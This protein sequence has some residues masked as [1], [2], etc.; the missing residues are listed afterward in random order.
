MAMKRS[1]FN[2]IVLVIPLLG[3]FLGALLTPH[4]V[5]ADIKSCDDLAALEADPLAQSAPVD[6]NDIQANAVITACIAALNDPLLG[7]KMKQDETLKARL[8]LQLGRGYLANE[9]MDKALIYFN[10]SADLNYPAG[11]FALGVFYLVGEDGDQ[12]FDAAYPALIKAFDSGVIW[13]A[14]ALSI[15]HLQE[16]TEYYDPPKAA[17]YQSLWAAR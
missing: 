10:Q 7:I 17:T 3:A 2:I 8:Y 9:E 16:N 4:N 15:L 12:N 14:R 11:H 13:A 1:V 6:F 5:K